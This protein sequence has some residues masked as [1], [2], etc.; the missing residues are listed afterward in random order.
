MTND[1]LKDIYRILHSTILV[2]TPIIPT[3]RKH[4]YKPIQGYNQFHIK[5]I[6]HSLLISFK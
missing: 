4:S 6:S 5:P 1:F 3:I 2:V